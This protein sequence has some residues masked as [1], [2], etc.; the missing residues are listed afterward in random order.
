MNLEAFDLSYFCGYLSHFGNDSA[1][2]YLVFQPVYKCFKKIADSDYISAW[3]PK[4]LPDES[5]KPLPATSNNNLAPQSN[6]IST[7]PRV[8]FD[9]SCLKQNKVI[10][11]GI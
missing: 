8:K 1:Y 9:G 2:N 3:K 4:G 7:K 10:F 5:I 11:M 6:Y